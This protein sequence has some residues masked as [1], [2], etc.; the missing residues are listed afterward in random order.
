MYT[1]K[2]SLTLQSLY[3]TG[4]GSDILFIS[5]DGR[6]FPLHKFIL[7]ERSDYFKT[8]L[9]GNFQESKQSEILLNEP[10]YA[11]EAI[12]Y[13]IYTEHFTIAMRDNPQVAIDV[14][15]LA[16]QYFLPELKKIAEITVLEGGIS[17]D[18]MLDIL[19]YAHLYSAS[20]LL[21]VCIKRII[22][23]DYNTYST[24]DEF[25]NLPEKTKMKVKKKS[26]INFMRL[27]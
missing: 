18:N 4:E 15:C 8:M 3:K 6:K 21:D 26:M 20:N 12:F 27:N 24:T 19:V 11:L 22:K 5:E 13:Y 14:V 23:L 1:I 25:N 9:T 17:D 16:D 10:G 7:Q 2:Y